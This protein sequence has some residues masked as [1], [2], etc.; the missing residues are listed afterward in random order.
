M[1]CTS[2]SPDTSDNC[3]TFSLSVQTSFPGLIEYSIK[4]DEYQKVAKRAVHR[5]SVQRQTGTF[6][7]AVADT[8][9]GA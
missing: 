7:D 5:P 8:M 4:T 1:Q 9:A 2:L 6:I 3:P